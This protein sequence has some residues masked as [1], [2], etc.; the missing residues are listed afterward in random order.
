MSVEQQSLDW[1]LF[2]IVILLREMH[3]VMPEHNHHKINGVSEVSC[4]F[5]VS[6]MSTICHSHDTIYNARFRKRI[7]LKLELIHNKGQSHLRIVHLNHA[8]Q[9]IT[10]FFF[11]K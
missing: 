11:L 3:S 5:H 7:L 4:L 1:F 2:P 8:H 10:G 9:N 6:F